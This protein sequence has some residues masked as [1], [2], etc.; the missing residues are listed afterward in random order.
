[1]RSRGRLIDVVDDEWRKDKLESGD[2]E[3][4]VKEEYL[5]PE[6]KE[7]DWSLVNKIDTDWID[8]GFDQF[9]QSLN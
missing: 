7:D 3:I 9:L 1:M 6:E 2:I 4:N 5:L 8:L